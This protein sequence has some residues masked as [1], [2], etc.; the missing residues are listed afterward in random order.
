MNEK[1][2]YPK[3][4]DVSLTHGQAVFVLWRWLVGD[5]ANQNPPEWFKAY[6]KYLRREGVPFYDHE[7]GIG[8]GGNVIYCYGHLMELALAIQLRFSGISHKDIAG[9]FIVIRPQLWPIF[10]QAFSEGS[11][12][13]GRGKAIKLSISETKQHVIVEGI[14][15]NTH[16]G[17]KEVWIAGIF[18]DLGLYYANGQLFHKTN[19]NDELIVMGPLELIERLPHFSAWEDYLGIIN[20]SRI[21]DRIAYLALNAPEIKRG[22]S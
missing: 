20:I 21:A 10:N 1:Q 5:T 3:I 17:T 19:S 16:Y 6:I 8:T 12:N 18:L 22:R 11:F 15:T 4:P 2:P 7:L 13:V 9:L 14:E